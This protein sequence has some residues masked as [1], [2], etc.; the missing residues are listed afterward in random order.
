[1]GNQSGI[2]QGRQGQGCCRHRHTSL[3]LRR[4]AGHGL[5]HDMLDEQSQQ[6]AELRVL[7]QKGLRMFACTPL[8]SPAILLAAGSSPRSRG[9]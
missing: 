9:G 4:H 8:P 6:P 3:R 7:G 1:M 5:W 2:W